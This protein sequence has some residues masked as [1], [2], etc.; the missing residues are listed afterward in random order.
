MGQVYYTIEKLDGGMFRA[1]TAADYGEDAGGPGKEFADEQ[2][3]A[4]AIKGLSN[5]KAK[6]GEAPVPP[7]RYRVVQKLRL[8]SGII[9]APS[10]PGAL[11]P[12]VV[13]RDMERAK[14]ARDEQRK[15]EDELTERTGYVAPVDRTEP[16]REVSGS[17]VSLSAED[18][19]TS[20]S[21]PDAGDAGGG[22]AKG[23]GK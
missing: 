10:S 6:K 13:A 8:P 18:R 20:T 15:A 7:G 5:G 16:R 19:V 9:G 14:K 2:S 22:K 12:P 1:M 3:A 4:E 11:D 23:K 21:D 17:P